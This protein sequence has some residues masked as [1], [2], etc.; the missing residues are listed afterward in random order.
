[1]LPIAA[2]I[3]A[4]AATDT[5]G[6]MDEVVRRRI[7]AVLLVAGIILGVLAIA[8]LGPFDDPPT[9]E[10]RAQETVEDF[11]AA[12]GEGDFKQFCSM[13]SDTAVTRIEQESA[14][15]A[16]QQDL[17][18]CRELVGARVGD[19][20]DGVS[21]IVK[22]VS[23]S[24]PRARVEANLKSSGEPGHDPLTV[25]LEQVDGDWLVNEFD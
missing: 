9:E 17:K 25:D 23:V 7:A 1:M 5:V 21:V 4:P 18:G 3:D 24:G 10:E 19:N 15:I 16:R 13:L 8:D 2:S 14:A 20:F 11:F 6:L 22:Q 12:A